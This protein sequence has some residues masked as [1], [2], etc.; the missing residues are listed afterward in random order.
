LTAISTWGLKMARV[1][2]TEIERIK[3]EI[4]LE[5]LAESG[6]V[7]LKAH[8]KDLLGRCPFH[9]DKTPSLVITPG[10]NLW[11]CLGA[12]QT[13]GSVIDWV[14]KAEGVSF[15]HAVE[16]LSEQSSSLVARQSPA[17]ALMKPP[18]TSTTRKLAGVL[19]T[20]MADEV[21]LER[22]V[23]FYE[24]SLVESPEALAYLK[25]R[26]LQHP[27]L[28]K[29]FRLGFANRTL[30]YRLPA[31]NRKGGAAIR[32]QLQHV[33][34]LRASGHE[35]FNGSIVI[36]VFD[37]EGKVVEMYGRKLNGNLRKGTPKHL[38]LPGQHRGVFNFGGVKGSKEL[39]LCESLIDA[40]TFWC[41]GFRNVTC[42]YGIEGFTPELKEA[43][44]SCDTTKVL[45]AY[46]RDEAGDKAAE[47]LAEELI[48]MGLEAWRVKFPRG[49]D[50]NEYAL[51]VGPA[52]KSLGA[53]IRAA[54]WMGKGAAPAIEEG[55]EELVLGTTQPPEPLSQSP[56]RE[57]TKEEVSASAPEFA[58]NEECPGDAK[59]Q[60]GTPLPPEISPVS[61][62]EEA[63][64][65][66]LLSL[67][68][69]TMPSEASVQLEQTAE[70]VVL[71]C[72]NRR[73]RVRGLS[74][75]SNPAAL[76]INLLVSHTEDGTFH[77]D[78]LELYSAR[79]R[80]AYIKQAAEE[81][82]TEERVIKKDLGK[83]LLKLEELQSKTQDASNESEN[84]RPQ[85]S[86][87]E[88]E[89]ALA[90][91]KDPRLLD[92][93]LADFDACGVV[94]ERTNKLVGYLAATSRKLERPLAIVVQSSSAAGKSSL[95]DAVLQMIP[96]E[97]RVCYSAMTGQ[98]LFYMGETELGH[99]ILAIAEEEGAERASYALK[100]LQS[101]GELTIA[102]TGKDPVTGR[103]IT[104]EYH[105]EGP[106]MLFL[107]TT[108]IE[109]D[110]E[111]L[112]RC[113]VL[114]V[115]E[116]REQ[117]HAIHELQRSGRTLK[118]LVASQEK[119][120]LQRL[121]QNAQR[122]L[123]S[124]HVV[125]PYAGELTFPD[126]QTRLRRD[127]MKYLCLID[128]IALLHQHQRPVKSVQHRGQALEYIE[129]TADDIAVAGELCGEV[130][131]RS[132]DELPPQTRRLLASLHEL[133]SAHC[134][135][136]GI[137]L[138]DLRFSR[139]DVREYMGWSLTQLRVHLA[140]LVELEYLLPHR[141]KRG[142]SFEYELMYSGEGKDGAPFLHGLLSLPEGTTPT[143]RGAEGKLAGSKRAQNGIG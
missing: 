121:H 60:E 137:E 19:E 62:K 57:A 116:N 129:V 125:N 133:V 83:I 126:H 86:D 28:L 104:E 131:G 103:H 41:A 94:G 33:G 11:H 29:T 143:W 106:V 80:S 24:K 13:G 102:S 85:M 65:G 27:E 59:S 53:A 18:K 26:G 58:Q 128:T 48:A 9:D 68:A 88:R 141:G 63:S 20:G 111:L 31:K 14:M 77:V 34:I 109:V 78:T 7:E 117:T 36:P 115:D 51:K 71:E 105:V 64:S 98:S 138:C 32:E 82:E 22:V 37:I 73:Y 67:V 4:S 17:G 8:G 23:S 72:G 39:L 119:S 35:H 55:R 99:K 139:R 84:K 107:T 47:K 96:E 81:L 136:Q 40:V 97:E 100:L 110:E 113:L 120:R 89:E 74:K 140:R 112:N 132:L 90:L 44:K 49:M 54:E 87:A 6:G 52:E 21:L 5:R 91:L 124:L 108:A 30:A 16:L 2:E 92:R 56:Q 79:Q 38:Y 46:D 25:S 15:R 50:A 43:L 3:A 61:P 101:E 123:R 76:K 66:Q 10:K 114:T 70:E 75:N 135:K 1:S 118:G 12:C 69:Q 95:M 45:I 122:L 142:Q 127:H 130:L 134:K 93:V 42:S